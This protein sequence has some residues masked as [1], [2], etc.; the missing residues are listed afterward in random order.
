MKDPA[1]LFYPNDYL[2]GTTGMTFE[3]K[4]AYIELL[5][6][7]FNKGAFTKEQAKKLLNG[8]FEHLWEVLSEKF[9]EIEGKFFNERLEKEKNKRNAFVEK[10]TS[11]GKKGGRPR[12]NPNET[13]TKPKTNP[14]HN[15]NKTIFINENENENENKDNNLGKSENPLK[16]E[17]N[18]F[19]FPTPEDVTNLPKPKINSTIEILKITAQVIL[20]EPDV[21]I[22]WEAFKQQNL[23]GKRYYLDEDAV[24]SHFMNWIKKT[25]FK[26]IEK[27]GKKSFNG[28]A[29]Q[30]AA[31]NFINS[32]R[33]EY[34]FATRGETID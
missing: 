22:M 25:D 24:E 12:K 14:N 4:G 18:N 21:L 6:M 3:E 10:Q 31:S 9:V 19:P 5:I 13:Q 29:K 26:K 2:G 20:G 33:D 28:S 1:F 15:P 17:K 23:T 32:A 11:I 16:T 27:N 30:Q 8:H 34:A 7:Q